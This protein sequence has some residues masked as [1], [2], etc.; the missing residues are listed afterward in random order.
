MANLDVLEEIEYELS[1]LEESV[2]ALDLLL[3]VAAEDGYQ[4]KEN[5][6]EV[7]A[8]FFARS[9]PTILAALRVIQRDIK[10][11]KDTIEAFVRR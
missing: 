10:T 3:D 5:F 2:I 4:T 1:F 7:K 6:N 9:F 11:R 8:I